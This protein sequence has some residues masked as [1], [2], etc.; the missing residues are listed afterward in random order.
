MEKEREKTVHDLDMALHVV[1]PYGS[2][3][4]SGGYHDIT[5]RSVGEGWEILGVG[6]LRQPGSN[7]RNDRMLEAA[8]V[9]WRWPKHA[10]STEEDKFR[11][12]GVRLVELGD[13]SRGD[14]QL[15]L[16]TD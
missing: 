13:K 4:H 14:K 6:C 11:R 10:T 3:R 2:H 5:L 8:S 1:P 12:C 15:D 16:E 9:H 7:F